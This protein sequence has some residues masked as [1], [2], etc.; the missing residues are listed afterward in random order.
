[1]P[2]QREPVTE[3]GQDAPRPDGLGNRAHRALALG[4]MTPCSR[5]TTRLASTYTLA[6][7]RVTPAVAGVSELEMALT[8][9]R[10]RPGQLK[11]A[12]T[13]N[14]FTIAYAKTSA[15][16]DSTGLSAGRSANRV[17]IV[18][19]RNPSARSSRAWSCDASSISVARTICAITPAG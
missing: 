4:S 7:S 13:R 3:A 6:T 8:A 1:R 10:P 11:T 15:I 14:P 17:R 2:G 5:S 16:S 12:S 19:S 18:V 9:Y